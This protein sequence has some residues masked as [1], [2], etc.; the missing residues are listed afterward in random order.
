MTYVAVGHLLYRTEVKSENI[1]VFLSMTSSYSDCYIQKLFFR[2][3]TFP[4]RETFSI[5][6]DSNVSIT[7]DSYCTVSSRITMTEGGKELLIWKPNFPLQVLCFL[8][9]KSV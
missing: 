1:K 8:S 9:L 3:Q 5:G 7:T 4:L 6:N 2:K